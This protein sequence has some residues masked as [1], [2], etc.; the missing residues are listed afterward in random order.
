MR[1]ILKIENTL[2]ENIQILKRLTDIT[3]KPI[4]HIDLTNKT[5]A[6]TA[7]I[8]FIKINLATSHIW[9]EYDEYHARREKSQDFQHPLER[10]QGKRCI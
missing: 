8:N 9:K 5:E 6:N 2:P 4:Q 7:N 3:A 10:S 1:N